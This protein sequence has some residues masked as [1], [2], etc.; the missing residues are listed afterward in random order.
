[1]SGPLAINDNQ[2]LKQGNF[3]TD[4]TNDKVIP[5]FTSDAVND[6][7]NYRPISI[8]SKVLERFVHMHFSSF[9]E[10]NDLITSVQSGFWCIHSTLTSLINITDRWLRNL[11]Q[12]L[13]TGIVLLI[14]EKLLIS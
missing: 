1:M 12:G 4:W 8:L 11:D 2:S 5:I 10:E 13:L 6:K 9:L 7:H 14:C 3:P